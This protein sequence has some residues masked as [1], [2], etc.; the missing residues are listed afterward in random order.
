M[1]FCGSKT[2]ILAEHENCFQEVVPECPMG[3]VAPNF[4]CPGP[5]RHRLNYYGEYETTCW[6][7]NNPLCRLGAFSDLRFSKHVELPN[8]SL[9]VLDK[10][11]LSLSYENTDAIIQLGNII[12]TRYVNTEA[13][14]EDLIAHLA[15]VFNKTYRKVCHVIGDL[16]SAVVVGPQW[17]LVVLDGYEQLM[18]EPR[19]TAEPPTPYNSETTGHGF[20]MHFNIRDPD[21]KKCSMHITEATKP[22]GWS[23]ELMTVGEFM[24]VE[25]RGQVPR[26][27]LIMS[28]RQLKWLNATIQEALHCNENIIVACHAP[29]HPLMVQDR[30]T[31]V[32]NWREILKLLMHCGVVRCCLMGQPLSMDYESNKCNPTY[33]HDHGILY[34][35]LPPVNDTAERNRQV[36]AHILIDLGRDFVRIRGEKVGLRPEHQ[37]YG[38]VHSFRPRT[39]VSYK[40][41]DY[42]FN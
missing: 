41:R 42:S 13:E 4:P 29:L 9:N 21:D 22:V 1:D 3:K 38:V 35:T 12:D 16:D 20:L 27:R 15:H 17:R 23:R 6:S 2:E 31:L 10:T 32:A 26:V 37:Q 18:V 14:V 25:E 33:H 36:S 34:Y 30:S 40:D 7:L 28:Q 8:F 24:T 5:Q 19:N 11:L 39:K